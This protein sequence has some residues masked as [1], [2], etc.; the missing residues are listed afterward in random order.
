MIEATANTALT[1][2]A[3]MKSTDHSKFKENKLT[4]T[5]SKLAASDKEI[6][7]YEKII[8]NGDD[9]LRHLEERFEAEKQDAPFLN[10]HKL[11]VVRSAD[12]IFNDTKGYP[13]LKNKLLANNENMSKGHFAEVARAIKLDKIG[14]ETIEFGAKIP[15]LKNTDIDIFAKN[16]I[17]GESLWVENK[18]VKSISLDDKFRRQIDNMSFAKENGVI[19]KDGTFVKPDRAIFVNSGDVTSAA[20]DYANTHGVE[21]AD[22][23]KNISK[24]FENF[25][26]GS[27]KQ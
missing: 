19:L 27:E 4:E 13:E 11:R 20:K 10:D 8:D 22:N 6:S 2:S 25:I 15:L 24:K 16:R 1:E 26:K 18:N 9:K 17:T 12:N 5:D 21:I 3:K 7:N 14:F 23:M